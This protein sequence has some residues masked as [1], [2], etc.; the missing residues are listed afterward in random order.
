MGSGC[1]GVGV[2]KAL[3]VYVERG[4][5]DSKAVGGR[6]VEP[7]ARN[8][9]DQTVATELGDEPRDTGATTVCLLSVAG[10]SAIEAGDEVGVAEPADGVAAGEHG[11]EQRPVGGAERVEAG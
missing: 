6:A 10:W 3:V 8:L 9:G 4:G 7:G 11:P 1:R 2:G 5:H